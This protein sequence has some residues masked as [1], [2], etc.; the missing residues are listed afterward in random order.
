MVGGTLPG[1]EQ[2]VYRAVAYAVLQA[3]EALGP[4]LDIATDNK[5]VVNQAD[6]IQKGRQVGPGAAA[7]DV[8]SKL[9][10]HLTVPG[11]TVRWIPAHLSE[12]SAGTG[13][14]S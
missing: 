10:R 7:A 9:Q 3:V 11:I 2:T 1:S 13:A 6:R 14:I 8:W 12:A 4:P 5:G